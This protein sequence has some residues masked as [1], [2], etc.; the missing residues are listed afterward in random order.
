MLTGLSTVAH[1]ELL[2]MARRDQTSLATARRLHILPTPG[3]A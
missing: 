1:S 3:L 2:T